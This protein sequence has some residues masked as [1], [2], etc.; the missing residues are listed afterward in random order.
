MAILSNM[1][2]V[3]K[4][5]YRP[6]LKEEAKEVDEGNA[7]RQ[8]GKK[9]DQLIVEMRLGFHLEAPLTFHH[10]VCIYRKGRLVKPYWEILSSNWSTG[11]GV[12][13]VMEQD[14]IMWTHNKQE[15]ESSGEGG[16][17]KLH[18]CRSRNS[19]IVLAA[20]L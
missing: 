3:L 6:K 12:I 7:V 19:A 4:Y 16:W 18:C 10:G 5:S 14:F 15:L 1:Q 17:L 13:G 8:R 20:W 9:G 11:R 2:H